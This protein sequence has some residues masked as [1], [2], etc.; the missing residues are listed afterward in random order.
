MDTAKESRFG[1]KKILVKPN[2]PN[3]QGLSLYPTWSQE[4][5]Q[6]Y[7]LFFTLWYLKLKWKSGKLILETNYG[8]LFQLDPKTLSPKDLEAYFPCIALCVWH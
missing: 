1:K 2:Q 4:C 6:K 7:S 8:K 5:Q 3:Q